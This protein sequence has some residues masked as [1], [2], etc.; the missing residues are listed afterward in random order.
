VGIRAAGP[1]ATELAA[2]TEPE[3]LDQPWAEPVAAMLLVAITVACAVVAS[4]GRVAR[5]RLRRASR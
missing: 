1:P 3:A 2:V 5:P 4:T